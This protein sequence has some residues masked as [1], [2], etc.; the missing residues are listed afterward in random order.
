MVSTLTRR[1]AE[2]SFKALALGA[3]DYVP[4]PGTNR[5]ISTS[6]DFRRE[7]I[8]K[9]KLLGRA[10]T[11]HARKVDETQAVAIGESGVRGRPSAK[12][13]S[14]SFLLG[15]WRLE[16]RRADPEALANMLGVASPSLSRI[17]VLIAQHMPPVFT[18][19]LAERLCAPP[20]ER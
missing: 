3:L 7:V 9:V 20:G 19:I 4:K 11:H 5:E 8:R 15:S 2:I 18:G 13:R 14:H 16:A 10:R 1:K 12:G 17:P 6:L